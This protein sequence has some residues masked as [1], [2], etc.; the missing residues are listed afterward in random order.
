MLCLDCHTHSNILDNHL[1]NKL[2]VECQA[3]IGT[4]RDVKLKL[5]RN[6]SSVQRAA[7]ALIQSRDSLPPSR[8]QELEEK[9]KS[10]YKVDELT[11][12]ILE[13]ARNMEVHVHNADY[14]PHGLKVVQYFQALEEDGLLVLERR[15]RE[16]FL[17]TMNPRHLP[18]LWSVEHHRRP[19]EKWNRTVQANSLNE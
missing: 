14:V 3:P 9:V 2:A 5:D 6:L 19:E 17:Q 4:E 8:L 7:N 1:K 16:H 13:K 10:Y 15:W 11:P 18:T 12:D